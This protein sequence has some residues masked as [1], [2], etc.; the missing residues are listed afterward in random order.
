MAPHYFPTVKRRFETACLGS[1]VW[2]SWRNV[3]GA[4][5]THCCRENMAHLKESRPDSGLGF[6]VKVHRTSKLSPLRSTAAVDN[7][8]H[9]QRSRTAGWF[10]QTE[11]HENFRRRRI[12]ARSGQMPNCTSSNAT[13]HRFGLRDTH[14]LVWLAPTADC[15]RGCLFLGPLWGAVGK[16]QLPEAS[17]EVDFGRPLSVWRGT[18]ASV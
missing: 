10:T 9:R 5:S 12:Q 11:A 13:P 15:W 2:G 7:S 1:G 16:R 4:G 3:F 8:D 17:R 14:I 18:H 6:Q